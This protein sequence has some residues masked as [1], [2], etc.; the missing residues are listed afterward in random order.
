MVLKRVDK[1]E[2]L[3]AKATDAVMGCCGSGLTCMWRSFVGGV[4]LA[5]GSVGFGAEL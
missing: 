5:R 2:R 1:S 4:P 3:T